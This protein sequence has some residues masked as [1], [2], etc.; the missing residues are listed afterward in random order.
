M[1]CLH[2][3]FRGLLIS[4]HPPA[5]RTLKAKSQSCNKEMHEK[6]SGGFFSAELFASSRRRTCCF[7]ASSRSGCFGQCALR[8]RA[9]GSVI[10]HLCHSDNRSSNSEA[11]ECECSHAY[12]F[13]GDVDLKKTTF[14]VTPSMR[15][16]GLRFSDARFRASR[17]RPELASA[18]P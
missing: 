3:N 14:G 2:V 7:C 15:V 4:R 18:R 1:R 17:S 13:S 16:F 9:S 5:T 8:I 10:G 11:A 6:G 12:T